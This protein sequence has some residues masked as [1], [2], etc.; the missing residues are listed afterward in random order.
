MLVLLVRH[1]HAL[2][3]S[4]WRGDDRDR[5]L[6]ARGRGQSAALVP[7]LREFKPERILS[8]P[9]SR[10][11]DTVVPLATAMGIDVE[12]DDAL[13]EGAGYDAVRLV[14]SVGDRVSVLCSHGRCDPGHPRRPGERRPVGP[15]PEPSRRKGVGLGAAGTEAEVHPG[16]VPSSPGGE[17]WGLIAGGRPPRCGGTRR[18]WRQGRPAGGFNSASKRVGP[19]SER[20]EAIFSSSDPEAACRRLRATTARSRPW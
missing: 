5:D 19:V 9:Y 7:I 3:R 16:R 18:R 20:T 4:G 10:C 8:S 14:R 1:A 12:P 2:A 15:G 11:V 17:G 13:A 6:S